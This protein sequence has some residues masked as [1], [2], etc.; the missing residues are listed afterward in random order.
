MQRGCV[1]F[2]FSEACPKAREL[3]LRIGFGSDNFPFWNNAHFGIYHDTRVS[4]ELKR[5]GLT[6]FEKKLRER[7]QNWGSWIAGYWAEYQD[8]KRL[9]AILNGLKESTR[10]NAEL[11]E[12]KQKFAERFR[13]ITETALELSGESVGS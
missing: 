6:L 7:T 12:F 11:L 9:L 1:F 3:G 8:G 13:I 4:A 2:D 5:K 10:E